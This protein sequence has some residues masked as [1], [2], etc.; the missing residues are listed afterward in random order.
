MAD[1]FGK[2]GI[3]RG[4]TAAHAR[5]K[6]NKLRLQQIEGDKFVDLRGVTLGSAWPLEN[7][8]MS[9]GRD[10]QLQKSQYFSNGPV[11][12]WIF[13]SDPTTLMGLP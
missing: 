11:G 7:T 1:S 9:D 2:S 5:G 12:E 10:S 8:T 13:P 3:W 6:S 4:G